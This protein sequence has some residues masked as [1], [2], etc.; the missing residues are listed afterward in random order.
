[1]IQLIYQ[2]NFFKKTFTKIYDAVLNIM[3]NQR[4]DQLYQ[5]F[6]PYTADSKL[7]TAIRILNNYIPSQN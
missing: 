5:T 1:M 7:Q 3:K 6:I 4:E 2:K